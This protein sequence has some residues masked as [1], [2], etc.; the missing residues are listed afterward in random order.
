MAEEATKPAEG[1]P[2]TAP[3]ETTEEK[4][5]GQIIDETI[6]PVAPAKAADETVPLAAFLDM[7][8]DNKELTKA[9]KD[10]QK[11]LDDGHASKEDIADDLDALASEFDIDPKFVS[12]LSRILEAKAEKK[13]GESMRPILEQ[14][15]KLTKKEKDDLIDTAFKK[16]YA[17]AIESMPEYADIANADAIKALSLLK[18]NANKTFAE[19]IENTYGK[20]ITGKRTIEPTKPGG[21]KEPAPLDYDRA[22]NDTE[23]FKEIMANPELKAQYNKKM[24]EPRGGRR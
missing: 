15:E 2:E 16:H 3:A 23:Y 1:A 11:K 19:L 20:A 18:E 4:T 14:N 13:V 5:V 7:K 10:L 24:L 8:K 12:K 6:P 22:K 9:V 17:K 21:G